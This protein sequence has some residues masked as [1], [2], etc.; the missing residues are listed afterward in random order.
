MNTNFSNDVAAIDPQ[1]EKTSLESD[2]K[3]VG[4]PLPT[5]EELADELSHCLVRN[6]YLACILL[7]VADGMHLR[8]ERDAL[9]YSR[10]MDLVISEIRQLR[11]N[12]LRAGDLLAVTEAEGEAVLIFL[13]PRQESG[14]PTPEHLREIAARIQ[15]A[16]MQRLARAKWSPCPFPLRVGFSFGIHNPLVHAKLS[17]RRM[18]DESRKMARLDYEVREAES[19]QRLQ[20]VILSGEISIVFQPIVELGNGAIYGFEALSRGPK[21]TAME[22]P[23][24]LFEQATNANLL[25][26]LDHVC[27][28]RAIRSSSRLAAGHQLFINTLPF[29]VRDPHFRGKYLL[30]LFEGTNLRP[31][32]IVL[33]VTEQIAIDDY[34]GY[35]DE[36]RYFSDM[37]CQCAIDD[38]GAG[39]SGLEKMLQIRPD[40]LK[41]DMHLIRGI[42]GSS[43]KQ[44]I[45]RAFQIMARKIGARIIA[46]GI[47]TREEMKVLRDLGL[48]YGQGYLIGRPADGFD[49]RH[50]AELYAALG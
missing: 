45:V 19:K 39:Y 13:I 8:Q 1:L 12:R 28:K 14:Q 36:M 15:T 21:G 34:A 42:D 41:L 9:L 48:D 2:G 40:Y 5:Y 23:L 31:E 38:V 50:Q 46:E 24:A 25:F 49:V 32:Q 37:G 18:V 26:E 7:D 4:G 29:S 30:E 33:E 11:G 43:V 6:G 27:R 20:H 22:S 3:L 16:L 17:L 10:L 47:E 44:E 35:V